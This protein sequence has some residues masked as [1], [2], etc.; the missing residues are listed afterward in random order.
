MTKADSTPPG[1]AGFS[2]SWNAISVSVFA[3]SVAGFWKPSWSSSSVASPSFSFHCLHATWHA[4][5]PMQ[6]A[7]SISVVL[8]GPVLGSDVMCVPL[9]LRIF[10]WHADRRR[11]R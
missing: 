10:V 11:P 2:V 5:Q 6:L 9:V 4:R 7:M 1:F 8:I 3:L